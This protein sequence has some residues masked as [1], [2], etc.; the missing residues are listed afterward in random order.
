MEAIEERTKHRVLN[1][2]PRR[3]DQFITKLIQRR[4]SIA[5]RSNSINGEAYLWVQPTLIF[6]PGH[7]C[8]ASKNHFHYR[9]LH[10]K[11]N[12]YQL[13]KAIFW[14]HNKDHTLPTMISFALAP[15]TLAVSKK[16]I[17]FL[18]AST[19]IW[20]PSSSERGLLYIPV[21]PI[22]PNPNLETWR[23][24]KPKQNTDYEL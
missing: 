10:Y 19:I 12:L 22:H 17:P 2:G 24:K 8:F 14:A 16:V 1:K 7:T 11:V 6:S 9:I 15:Y 4:N 21:R 18:K 13:S 20:I 23:G 3:E 5:F